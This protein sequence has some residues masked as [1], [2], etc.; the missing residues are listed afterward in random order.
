MYRYNTR[1]A[2]Q[3]AYRRP[4]KDFR[5]G[6]NMYAPAQR[7]RHYHGISDPQMITYQ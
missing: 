4:F 3:P 6:Q 2:G 5:L 7:E 1:P